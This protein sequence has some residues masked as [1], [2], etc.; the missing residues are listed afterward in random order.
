MADDPLLATLLLEEVF[1]QQGSQ[2]GQ[3]HGMDVGKEQGL[4]LGFK[5]GLNL[6]TEV[7][8]FFCFY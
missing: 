6:G 2:A 4:S 3:Q 1:S 7:S 8:F 5:N